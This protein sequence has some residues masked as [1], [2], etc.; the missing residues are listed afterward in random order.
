MSE[1]TKAQLEVELAQVR[2]ALAQA[3]ANGGVSQYAREGRSASVSLDWLVAEEA[4]LMSRIRAVSVGRV[5]R[6]VM[7]DR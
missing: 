1:L 5:R 6:F 2:L 7:L 4:R 3:R